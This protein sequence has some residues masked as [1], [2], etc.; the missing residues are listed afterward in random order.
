MSVKL[1][2]MP[3]VRLPDPPEVNRRLGE[4]LKDLREKANLTQ[5]ALATAVGLERTSI[6]N[7]EAG[8]QAVSVPLLVKLC[9]VLKVGPADLVS[10]D[11]GVHSLDSAQGRFGSIARQ[12]VKHNTRA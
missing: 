3:N 2:Y 4:T 10:M 1:T 8:L 7:I 9:L 6:T 12:I 11:D 5:A